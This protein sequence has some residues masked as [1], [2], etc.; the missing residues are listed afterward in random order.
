VGIS[1]SCAIEGPVGLFTVHQ[2]ADVSSATQVALLWTKSSRQDW[3]V[4][5]RSVLF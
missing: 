1:E 4:T 3:S 5:V 2:S